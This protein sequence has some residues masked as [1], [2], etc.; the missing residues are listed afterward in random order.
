MAYT[1]LNYLKNITEGNKEII[2]EM[3]EM[4]ILQVPVFISN[5]N[6]L[7]QTGQYAA[8]GKEAHKA[9][10]SLQIM[11]MTDMEMEMKR[12]QLKTIEGI[13]MESYPDHIRNFENQCKVALEELRIELTLL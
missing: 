1:N 9:K 11:G 12:F 2:R 5:L 10:S 13:E 6:N 7:Y 8:L 4:F 3:I